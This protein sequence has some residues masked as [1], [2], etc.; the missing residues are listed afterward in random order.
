MTADNSH[1][2]H[3]AGHDEPYAAAPAE[4]HGPAPSTVEWEEPPF[5]PMTN[6]TLLGFLLGRLLDKDES[7]KKID[8][9][10]ND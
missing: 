6:F 1:N 2:A 8:V 10:L 3:A 4:S 7:E 9:V 5:D